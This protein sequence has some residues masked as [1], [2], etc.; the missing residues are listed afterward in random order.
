MHPLVRSR[1]PVARVH[2]ERGELVEH[3]LGEDAYLSDEQFAA[4][5]AARRTDRQQ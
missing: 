2:D 3:D 5:E 4:R 1:G